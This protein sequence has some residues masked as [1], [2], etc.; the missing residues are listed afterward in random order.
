MPYSNY[1]KSKIVDHLFR[2][3]ASTPV[4]KVYIAF[5][6]SNP[7][8]ADIGTEVTGCAYARQ[9]ITYGEPSISGEDTIIQNINIV[10]FPVASSNWGMVT[11]YGI[12]DAL[13]GGNLLQ[14]RYV[15]NS[16]RC[17]SRKST[18]RKCRRINS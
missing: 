16:T 12:R 1:A 13:T 10:T 5:Y 4:S 18:H 3:V 17:C 15:C 11:H 9:E 8:D 14:I 7:T 2:G 6:I